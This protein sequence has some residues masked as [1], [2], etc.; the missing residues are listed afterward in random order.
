[1]MRFLLLYSGPPTAPDSS[2]EGWPEWFSNIG[3]ALVDLGSPTVNGFVVHGDGPTSDPSRVL[4]G[5]SIVQA[6]DR[7]AAL[8]LVRDHPLLALGSDYTIEVFET[9]KR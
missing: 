8:D 1:M 2:H 4:N 9:P 3:D 7:S 6:E 5:Y